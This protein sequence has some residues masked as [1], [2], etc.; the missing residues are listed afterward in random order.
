M[1]PSLAKQLNRKI[2]NI[3]LLKP[4]I[5]IFGHFFNCNQCPLVPIAVGVFNFCSL[6]EIQQLTFLP[7]SR[8]S[9]RQSLLTE[10]NGMATQRR[11]LP[12]ILAWC[13]HVPPIP[14]TI[15]RSSF[16]VIPLLSFICA[17][18]RQTSS[19]ALSTRTISLA[20]N[21]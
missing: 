19:L 13:R 20:C 12:F 18:C 1:H 7:R 17:K 3:I 8:S 16:S 2:L 5:N 6:L 11:L 10:Q 15:L 9:C 14:D 4:N 21:K